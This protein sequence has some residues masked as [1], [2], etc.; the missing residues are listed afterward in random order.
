MIELERQKTLEESPRDGLGTY[1]I[2][3][4]AFQIGLLLGESS[5]L[6]P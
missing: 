6:T 1:A 4:L 5:L 2:L 3:F